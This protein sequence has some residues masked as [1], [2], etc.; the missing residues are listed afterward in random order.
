MMGERDHFLDRLRTLAIV[1]VLMVHVLYWLRF[2][3]D[4]L[5]SVVRS[6]LLLEMPLFFF[7]S[8]AGQS[9]SKSRPW[10]VFVC[11]SWRRVLIPY[12]CY[13]LL[14]LLLGLLSGSE[15]S[16]Q[17]VLWWLLPADRQSALLP[18]ST[19]ALWYVPVYLLCVPVMPLL[20]RLRHRPLPVLALL[21]TLL[22]TFERL[23][24]YYPQNVAFYSL[25]IYAGLQ[26]P[27]LK[28]RYLL[29]KD[30]RWE[31]PAMA[32]LGLGLTAALCR[33]GGASAD[34]QFNKFPPN[35]VFLAYSLCAMSLL[36]LAAPTIVR[37]MDRLGRVKLLDWGM[38]RLG[39]RSLSVFLYQ[40]LAFLLLHKLMTVMGAAGLRHSVQFG[41][42]C[43]LAIILAVILAAV[44]GPLENLGRRKNS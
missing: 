20:R 6:W 2:F 40:P 37:V 4:G 39:S 17:T 30:R 31:L 29:R 35:G 22:L 34:M 13:A 21:V 12:W 14:C 38:N 32:V 9:L 11:R 23:G 36:A 16:G 33:W 27:T 44:F 28:Q 43:V 42:C 7:L 24:W 15:I 26:Y 3:P 25:W 18:F 8:G 10:A 5:L 1:W 41:V 19:D